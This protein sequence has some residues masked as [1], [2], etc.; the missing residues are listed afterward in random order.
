M[1]IRRCDRRAGCRGRGIA[2]IVS[3]EETATA[4]NGFFFGDDDGL[5]GI[6]DEEGRV[7]G[8]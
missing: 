8:E 6:G 7:V 1:V 2:A 3:H 5:S 4:G